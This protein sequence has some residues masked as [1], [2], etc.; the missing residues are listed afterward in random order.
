MTT[1]IRPQKWVTEVAVHALTFMVNFSLL[2]RH[3]FWRD[4][5]NFWIIASGSSSI[6][7]LFDRFSSETRPVLWIFLVWLLSKLWH[8]KDVLIIV[9]SLFSFDVKRLARLVGAVWPDEDFDIF[10]LA[11]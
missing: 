8:D 2:W 7:D 10:V 9:R 5:T 11:D 3:S 1:Q 4:S 6:S